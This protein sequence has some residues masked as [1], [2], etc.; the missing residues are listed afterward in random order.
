MQYKQNLKVEESGCLIYLKKLQKPIVEIR[1]ISFGNMEIMQKKYTH[2][3]IQI[4]SCGF[5]FSPSQKNYLY[6]T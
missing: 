6:K 1:T 5:S 3:A 2:I 4:L